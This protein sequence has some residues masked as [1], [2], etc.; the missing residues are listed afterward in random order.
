MACARTM[1]GEGALRWEAVGSLEKQVLQL[2]ISEGGEQGASAVAQVRV[3]FLLTQ[4]SVDVCL[5]L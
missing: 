5:M 4:C 1:S 3:C 2:M